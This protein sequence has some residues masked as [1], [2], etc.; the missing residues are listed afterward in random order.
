MTTPVLTAATAMDAAITSF[1]AAVANYIGACATANATYRGANPL[2]TDGKH[3]LSAPEQH[4]RG[5]LAAN[6]LTAT[7]LGIPQPGPSL[8]LAVIHAND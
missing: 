6:G 7:V 4:L 5:A 1:N 3:T 8:T 2:Q